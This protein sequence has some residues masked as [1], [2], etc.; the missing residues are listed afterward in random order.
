[1]R[2]HPSRAC[3]CSTNR[4]PASTTKSSPGSPITSGGQ[5]PR[6]PPTAAGG[7]Y[8]K[9]ALALAL[10]IGTLIEQI[11][12]DVLP[13]EAVDVWHI[14]VIVGIAFFVAR[15]YRG[16]MRRALTRRRAAGRR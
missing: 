13:A 16:F 3:C 6:A 12:N 14:A 9:A 8:G 1:M 11:A 5:R 7:R 10:L 15:W 4:P 2:S